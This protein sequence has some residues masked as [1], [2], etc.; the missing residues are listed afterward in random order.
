[1]RPTSV[2]VRYTSVEIALCLGSRSKQLSHLRYLGTS[3]EAT[4]Q[5]AR[6]WQAFSLTADHAWSWE[7]W[8]CPD[9]WKTRC[10][11]GSTASGL[12]ATW[13]PL[14]KVHHPLLREGRTLRWNL[15]VADQAFGR[16]EKEAREKVL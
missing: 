14:Y 2:G 15:E 7:Q 13:A 9:H 5:V 1:M 6:W 8:A 10:V 16:E 4:M 11:R 3:V 12:V